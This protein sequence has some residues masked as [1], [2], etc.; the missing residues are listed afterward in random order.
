MPQLSWQKSTFS[1]D[2][3]NCVYVATAPDG[4]IR[5]RES[6]AP[7]TVMATGLAQLALLIRQIKLRA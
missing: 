7:D 4:T 1:E 5:L 2:Q 3:A 6:D